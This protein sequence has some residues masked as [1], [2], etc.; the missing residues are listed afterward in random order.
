MRCSYPARQGNNVKQLEEH[1]I[2]PEITKQNETSKI[3]QV[4]S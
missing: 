4:K 1:N 2:I 3:E